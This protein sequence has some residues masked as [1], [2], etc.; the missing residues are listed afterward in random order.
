VF[1]ASSLSSF[2]IAAVACTLPSQ[3]TAADPT[4]TAKRIG[5]QIVFTAGDREVLH[6]QAEPGEFPRANI[7]EAY[8]RGGYLHPIYTPAGRLVTDDFPSNHIHHHGIWMPWTKTEFEG[9]TPDFWNM[10]DGK[11]RVEFVS[12]EPAWEKDNRAGFTAKHQFV[13]LTVQ[14]SKVALNET[15]EI[16]VSAIGGATPRNVI[17]FT[18]T[19]T[20]ATDAPL[21]LPQYHYGGFGFRGNWAWN[22]AS[23]FNV[24]TSE[25]ETDRNKANESR[26][27][28]CR[29]GGAV[30]GQI[31]SATILCHPDNYRFPQ[32][33]RLHP[34]EPFF[35]YAPQQL[36]DMEI[37][38]G[39]PYV[40]KYRIIITE[41]APTKEEADN[42]WRQW[43]ERK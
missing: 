25:G 29:V 15:W 33:M 26:G 16:A 17:D 8:R 11:G 37:T 21:K 43:A 42:W 23:A 13:D 24:L 39:K 32:P 36:G 34:S 9:R 2:V 3:L 14:P 19:Q 27:K 7:K 5:K 22:G 38:P 35:C 31:A 40:S 1:P 10:G 41:G 20:C 30:D 4:V 28:W 12:V 6:Y 18:S